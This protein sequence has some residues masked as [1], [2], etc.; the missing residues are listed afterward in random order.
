MW[1]LAGFAGPCVQSPHCY[2]FANVSSCVMHPVQC[3]LNTTSSCARVF[4]SEFL[5]PSSDRLDAHSRDRENGVQN[6][7]NRSFHSFSSPHTCAVWSLKTT[8]VHRQ[9]IPETSVVTWEVVPVAKTASSRAPGAG[10]IQPTPGAVVRPGW[11][12]WRGWWH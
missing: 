1:P 7:G 12:E 8:A 3:G 11:L 9:T 10:R 4:F 5:V 2:M 6:V